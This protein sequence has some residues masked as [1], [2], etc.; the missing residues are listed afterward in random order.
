MEGVVVPVVQREPGPYKNKRMRCQ[1]KKKHL[2]QRSGK[3][4]SKCKSKHMSQRWYNH[5]NN[6]K[7]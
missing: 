3:H 5:K 6:H 2:N 1:N 7:T 4:M